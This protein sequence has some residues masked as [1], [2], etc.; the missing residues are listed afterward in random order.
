MDAKQL[1]NRLADPEFEL[2]IF[3]RLRAQTGTLVI[4]A[5]SI[6]FD[7]DGLTFLSVEN[8]RSEVIS[9]C[10]KELKAIEALYDIKRK[11]V[12]LH[13]FDGEEDTPKEIKKDEES[14]HNRAIREAKEYAE[15][16]A[17]YYDFTHGKFQEEPDLF[18]LTLHPDHSVSEAFD[19]DS[20][21]EGL[22]VA[23]ELDREITIANHVII[24]LRNKIRTNI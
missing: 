7:G 20:R 11:P 15:M 8:G 23:M 17:K 16:Q 5:Q 6:S 4:L 18:D 3:V 24:K 19:D 2:P 22:R 1:Q 12:F 10:W 9:F 21:K 14:E 13:D